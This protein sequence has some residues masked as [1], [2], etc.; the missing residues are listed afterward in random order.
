M[1]TFTVARVVVHR[2]ETAEAGGENWRKRQTFRNINQ[3][4][5]RR[6]VQRQADNTKTKKKTWNFEHFIICKRL[7]KIG[8]IWRNAGFLECAL[9]DWHI[10]NDW[11][12]PTPSGRKNSNKNCSPQQLNLLNECN[13]GILPTESLSL[14]SRSSS[15]ALPLPFSVGWRESDEDV[16]S[17]PPAIYSFIKGKIKS[18]RGNLK[19][20]MKSYLS[21]D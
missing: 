17:K 2:R 14:A 11:R 18:L 15:W 13:Y 9:S 7:F 4:K 20:Q 21:K 12:C 3:W 1:S 16:P 5:L 10:V 6:F 8:L 19:S